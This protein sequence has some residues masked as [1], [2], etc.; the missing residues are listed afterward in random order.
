MKPIIVF[1]SHGYNTLGTIRGLATCGQ[2]VFLLLVGG[3]RFYNVTQHSRYIDYMHCAA[4]NEE[5]L[6]WL[7][8][9]RNKLK[10]SVVYPT[11]DSAESLLDIS[12]N[13]LCDYYYFPHGNRQ[14]EV[15]RLMD[16]N[17]QA[18]MAIEAGLNVPE[19]Y[20]LL[21][22]GSKTSLYFPCLLK[23]KASIAGSKRDM[24]VC[25]SEEE[26]R[27][28]LK[29]ARHTQEFIAQQFIDKEYDLLLIGCAM[30]DG[31]VLIPGLFK[32][33]RWQQL[34]GDGTYG[35]I[36]TCVEKYF[37]QLEAA[38]HFVKNLHYVGPFS[39]EFGVEKGKAY[40]YEINLRNDGTSHYFHQAGIYIPYW[41][42]TAVQGG[43]YRQLVKTKC[44]RE[45]C[46]IDEFED[47]LNVFRISL[48]LKKWLRDLRHATVYKYYD[49]QDSKPFKKLLPK[50]IL[51][52]TYKSLRLLFAKLTS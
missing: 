14:G 27:T 19:C 50:Q 44:E 47:F 34:G 22:G 30:P 20:E 39:M 11:S 46:F 4:N 42:A 38:R 36:T 51:L 48:S 25:R 13:E 43:D 21:A 37:G 40:F 35:L 45:Y 10:G 6:G 2:E 18:S 28:C 12:Y 15:T 23:S 26:L 5:A 17:L 16:K 32:K 9:N 1:G 49:K 52:I 31:E 24:A 33:E 8:D 41:F 29:A 3:S 7:K